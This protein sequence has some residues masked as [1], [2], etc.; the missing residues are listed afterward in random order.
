[1]PQKVT[2]FM[3]EGFIN[4]FNISEKILYHSTKKNVQNSWFLKKDGAITTQTHQT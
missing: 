2:R 4:R 3:G 1:V